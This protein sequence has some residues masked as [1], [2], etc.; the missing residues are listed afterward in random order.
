MKTAWTMTLVVTVGVLLT[1]T[2]SLARMGTLWNWGSL[3]LDFPAEGELGPAPTGP[4]TADELP[5]EKNS[6]QSQVLPVAIAEETEFDFGVAKNQTNDH[7]HTFTVRND[8]E[9]P[10]KFVGYDVSCNKCTFV[11][12]PTEELAPGESCEIVVRWNVDTFEDHFRQSASVQTNDPFHPLLR[13]VISGQV[14]RALEIAPRELVLSN[15]QAG[16][17]AAVKARLLAYFSDELRIVSH[18]F[19][20]AATAEYFEVETAP[21]ADADLPPGAKSGLE[22]TLKLQPGLPLG[23]IQQTLK[24]TTNLEDAPEAEIPIKGR[25]SGAVSIIGKGWDKDRNL[26]EIGPVRRSAGGHWKLT[27]VVRGPHR[28]GLKLEPPEQ[29]DADVLRITYGEPSAVKGGATTL[30]PLMFEIPPQSRLVS[31]MGGDT[32]KLAVV[33]IPTNKSELGRV[34]MLVKFA[35]VDD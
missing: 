12:L 30:I 18:H 25:V 34:K 26:L 13:F 11:D 10:L 21:L 15:V 19:A 5:D 6:A 1:T 32:G 33:T 17:P 22:L 35:V 3:S 27:L 14:V 29:T 8:G 2:I 28:E 24:L 23:T 4:S 20:D 7:R 16:V 9:A 31:H